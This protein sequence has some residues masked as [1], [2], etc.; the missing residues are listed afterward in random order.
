MNNVSQPS[1]LPAR[2]PRRKQ[3]NDV[4]ND[5][6]NLASKPIMDPLDTPV[7]PKHFPTLRMH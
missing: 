2:R 4:E 3:T 1:A 6:H 5:F 7:Q